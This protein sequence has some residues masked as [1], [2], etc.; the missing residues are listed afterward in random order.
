MLFAEL[1]PRRLLILQIGLDGFRM[2]Q[3]ESDGPVY[4]R[5]RADRRIRLQ[6]RFRRISAA[7]VVDQDVEA[8]TRAG[9][10]VSAVATLDVWATRQIGHSGD[11]YSDF[12]VP[13]FRPVR[14][15]LTSLRLPR[16]Q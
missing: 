7:E 13:Y 5:Q 4:L 12:R 9:Y 6:D 1:C 15:N 8:D 2:L 10:V 14:P 16:L 3:N 11:S